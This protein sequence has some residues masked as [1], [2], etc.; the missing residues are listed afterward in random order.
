[1]TIPEVAKD[2]GK[3]RQYVWAEI[4]RWQKTGGRIGLKAEKIGRDW[5][6]KPSDLKKYQDRRKKQ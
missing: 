3:S 4:D 6:V 2:L 1:M 5:H